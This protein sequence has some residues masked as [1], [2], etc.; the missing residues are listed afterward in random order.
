M[1]P[2]CRSTLLAAISAGFFDMERVVTSFWSRWLITTLLA[3]LSVGPPAACS[4]SNKAAR[5]K[6]GI[7]SRAWRPRLLRKF[8]CCYYSLTY[9]ETCRIVENLI[10]AQ[11][12]LDG[13]FRFTATGGG[14]LEDKRD[15]IKGIE[16]LPSAPTRVC[17]ERSGA[18]YTVIS[19]SSPRTDEECR[20]IGSR[21][22]GL[23][24]SGDPA[25]GPVDT[26]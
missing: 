10:L 13:R 4:T 16:I 18:P 24:F 11:L 6:S 19:R 26:S 9:T 17:P 22:T 3:A 1:S 20:R 14:P 15:S 8:R 12:T 7:E 21:R 23:L 2:G 5:T 25:G